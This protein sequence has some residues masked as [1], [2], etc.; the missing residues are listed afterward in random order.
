MAT[1]RQDLGPVTAY[2]YAVSEGYTGTEEEFAE[3]LANFA[4]SA[5]QVAADAA[6]GCGA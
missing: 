3:V 4:D 2:A 6:Q 1:L 5:E